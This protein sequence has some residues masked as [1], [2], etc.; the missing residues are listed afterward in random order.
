MG[1][2]ASRMDGRGERVHISNGK[3]V[4]V[5][6]VVAMRLLASSILSCGTLSVVSAVGVPN[7]STVDS[8]S[9]ITVSV[10]ASLAGIV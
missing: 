4:V 6:R 10:E 2:L 9:G 3:L 5:L 7:N 8:V 1:G